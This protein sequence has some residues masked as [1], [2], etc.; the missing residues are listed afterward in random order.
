M[1]MHEIKL[2][3]KKKLFG[4]EGYSWISCLLHLA[5]KK[6]EVARMQFSALFS[7][8]KLHILWENAPAEKS[9]EI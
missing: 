1:K 7:R 4:G 9:G 5:M 6:L 8:I 3:N 2:W